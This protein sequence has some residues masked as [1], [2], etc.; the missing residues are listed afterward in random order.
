L[1]RKP[2]IRQDPSRL[3]EKKIARVGDKRPDP[4]N[5]Q[6]RFPVSRIRE[7]KGGPSCGPGMNTFWEAVISQQHAKVRDYRAGLLQRKGKKVRGTVGY[8]VGQKGWRRGER[9]RSTGRYLERFFL[10]ADAGRGNNM[11]T[12]NETEEESESITGGVDATFTLS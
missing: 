12:E 6:A 8:G 5:R 1:G 7:G 10:C 3:L 2:N 9:L 4:A 11:K